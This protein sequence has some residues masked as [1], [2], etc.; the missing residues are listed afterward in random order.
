MKGF[1]WTPDVR[2]GR[3]RETVSIHAGTSSGGLLRFRK[4][5]ERV[6][7]EGRGRQRE[8]ASVRAGTPSGK[9]T[10]AP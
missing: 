1:L 2:R 7:A 10:R 4:M 3:Q 6:G 8:I 9:T 5:T